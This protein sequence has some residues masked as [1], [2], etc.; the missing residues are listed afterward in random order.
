MKIKFVVIFL[1]ITSSFMSQKNIK[2]WYQK[3]ATEY[4]DYKFLDS[5]IK[6]KNYVFIGESS[7]GAKEFY[8]Q[9]SEIVNYL[10][11]EKGFSVVLFESPLMANFF[12]EYYPTFRH[13]NET[14]ASHILF[15]IFL[16]QSTIDLIDDLDK[17]SIAVNGFDTQLGSVFQSELATK[18]VYDVFKEID[19][20]VANDFYEVNSLFSKPDLVRF[21]KLEKWYNYP[22]VNIDYNTECKYWASKYNDYIHFAQLNYHKIMDHFNK[23]SIKSNYLLKSL[24]MQKNNIDNYIYGHSNL[25]V[26]D[27]L[28]A[29]NMEF[30]ITNMYKNRKVIIWSHNG[31]IAKKHEN[32]DGNFKHS[33]T[34]GSYLN[35]TIKNK[36]FHIG[37]YSLRGSTNNN[38]RKPKKV[39]AYKT[40]GGVENFLKNKK[41]PKSFISLKDYPY[42]SINQFVSLSHW[43][44]YPE[45]MDP[46]EQFDLLL[47]INKT[48]PCIYI[49]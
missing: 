11:R 22:C 19:T 23:D 45:K 43:G 5:L 29:K 38:D 36:S 9:K 35:D 26:R 39:I 34:M 12:Y 20:A 3:N 37:L 32:M 49:E 16:N 42:K 6:D 31:H 24:N 18:F 17:N 21:S 2:K 44:V 15:P 41:Y 14:H 13:P 46:S 4:A 25:G 1:V 7:H 48:S 28:M 8:E 33:K 30:L 10:V 40:K 47:F 27:S